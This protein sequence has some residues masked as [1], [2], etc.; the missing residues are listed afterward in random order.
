MS[1]GQMYQY[2]LFI[3]YTYTMYIWWCTN[4]SEPIEAEIVGN[5]P[6]KK[7]W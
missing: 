4:Y 1:S 2:T 6:R 7:D 5:E 3:V